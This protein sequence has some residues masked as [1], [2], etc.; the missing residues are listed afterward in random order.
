MNGLTRTATL[1][2]ANPT[3]T[4]VAV[5]PATVT[6]GNAA[7]GTVTLSLPA[8]PAGA[9]VSLASS[10]P[11]A[12]DVPATVSVAAGSATATFPI[13]T[14]SSNTPSTVTITAT[15]A[16]ISRTATL[17]VAQPTLTAVAVAPLTVTGGNNATGTVTLSL[18]AGPAGAVVTLSSGAPAVAGVPASVTVAAGSATATFPIT[19]V[20]SNTPS[21]VI[22]TAT[23]AAISR[24]AT[25]AVA[26]PTLSTLAVAP[27]AL[28]GGAVSTGTVTLTLP[29]GPAG[30]LISLTNSAP[31]SATLPASVTV[32]AGATSATFA[33]STTPS[34]VAGSVIVTAALAGVS[35][36][37]TIAIAASDPCVSV[38][39]LGGTVAVVSGTLPQFRSTRLRTDLVGDVTNNWINAMGN[40]ATAAVPTV[41]FISGTATAT[42]AGTTTSVMPAGSLT[43]GPLTSPIPAEP[44]TVLATDAVGN[45]LQVI[46]PALAGLPAGPPVLRLNMVQWTAAVQ[47][48][49]RLDVTLTFVARGA[50]GSLTT[51]T[52]SGLGMFVPTFVP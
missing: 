28:T 52:A 29:A 43:F 3:L 22:I 11:G 12:A 6:G 4:A 30:A 50:D 18:P 32:A 36:T 1:A 51:F 27:A 49:V 13:T 20:S 7:T 9:V 44:G 10:T 26:Q 14:V 45:V 34:P 21:S 47:T 39:Q 48:N 15:L 40:C 17:T 38:N 23:L 41:G 16:A 5:A 31:A 46:W 37:A 2:V 24:T 25:L 42:L 8:G 35:R 33:I 19:T